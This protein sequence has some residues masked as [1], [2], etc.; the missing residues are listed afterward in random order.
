M[1]APAW[2]ALGLPVTV[3]ERLAALTTFRLGGPCAAVVR[4]ETPEE[5]SRAVAALH[6]AGAPRVV[7]GGGS[8][9]LAADAGLD[10]VVVRYFS[11]RPRWE[12]AEHEIVVAGSVLLDDLAAFLAGRGWD[13][14][15]FA[16]GIPGTVGGAVAGNA[17]AFGVQIGDA[18]LE[19]QLVAPDGALRWVSAARLGF[20]YRASGLAASG[21]LVAAVRLQVV[22]G[23]P[24]ALARRREEILELRRRKHPDWRTLPTA[25]SFFKNIAP[26]SAAGRRQAAGWFLEEA[27]AKAM[28]VG[29]ARVFEQHANIIV[30]EP[31]CTAADVDALARRMADAVREKFG[32]VLEP[33]VRR[34]GR[35]A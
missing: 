29:G 15:G 22:P 10:A 4:C 24:A 11:H 5:L 19:A 34:L 21:E 13:G 14:L 30:A 27:G 6:R 23:D 25:G 8:N 33:E 28:R 7:V 32:L 16:S 17:G 26:T 9:I 18:V 3:G 12:P 31:G 2:D 1:S 20:A 35:F